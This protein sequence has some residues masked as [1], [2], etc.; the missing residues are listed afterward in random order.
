MAR[1]LTIK[2]TASVLTNANKDAMQLAT[3]VT[4][5]N[6]L[7]DRVTKIVEPMLPNQVKA[8]MLFQPELGKA[9]ISNIAAGALIKFAPANEKAQLAANAMIQA[10]ML[11]FA[12]SFNIEAMVN[13]L[14][15]GLDFSALAP[16]SAEG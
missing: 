10:S 1:G 6:I 11:K 8:M 13:E 4:I 9:I 12:A 16:A 15:D 7:N 14:L 3:S 2:E 5:G